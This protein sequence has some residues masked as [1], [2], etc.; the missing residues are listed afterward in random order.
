[1]ENLHKDESASL[2][3]KLNRKCVWP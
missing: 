2:Q 1:M 3:L